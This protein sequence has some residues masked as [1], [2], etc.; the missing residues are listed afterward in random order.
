MAEGVYEYTRASVG[1][2]HLTE[3]KRRADEGRGL[4]T[5]ISQNPQVRNGYARRLA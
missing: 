5:Y 4:S 2:A 1:L 3:M